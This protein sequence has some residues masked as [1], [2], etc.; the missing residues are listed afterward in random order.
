MHPALLSRV[1]ALGRLGLGA[2]LVAR[3]GLLTSVW[4]GPDAERGSSQVL[5]R[6]LGIR[7]LVIA[8]GTLGSTG[9]EQ[10]RWLTAALIADA[11]DLAVTLGA[12]AALPLRGRVLV[13]LAA[14]GGVAMGV[15]ALIGLR[16]T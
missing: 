5:A 12:G 7:D 8:A 16:R 9:D 6:A 15:A 3:P 4:V 11:T 14:G 13:S 10:Q 1:S 2:G